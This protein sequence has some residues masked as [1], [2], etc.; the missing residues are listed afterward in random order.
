MS[1]LVEHRPV[2]PR[3]AHN[4]E[5]G[6]TANGGRGVRQTQGLLGARGVPQDDSARRPQPKRPASSGTV[7]SHR[8]QRPTPAEPLR[9]APRQRRHTAPPAE[10]LRP[11]RVE[12]SSAVSRATACSLW[13]SCRRTEASVDL[14]DRSCSC[15]SVRSR[16]GSVARA[17]AA[18][19]DAAVMGSTASGSPSTTPMTT[20]RTGWGVRGHDPNAR[21][22]RACRPWSIWQRHRRLAAWACPLNPG[23]ATAPGRRGASRS[24][25]RYPAGPRRAATAPATRVARSRAAARLLQVTVRASVIGT[26]SPST[27]WPCKDE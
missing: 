18:L 8:G 19:A 4:E 23:V 12:S 21:C 14:S 13:S 22:R 16:P 1:D 11:E 2:R 15:R 20:S 9:G 25:R 27:P 5:G 3:G 26:A 24:S 6:G 10:H 7:R 17:K